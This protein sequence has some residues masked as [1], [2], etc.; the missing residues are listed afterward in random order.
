[1]L[2]SVRT[3]S[4]FRSRSIIIARTRISATAMEYIQK[5]S[6]IKIIPANMV[7]AIDGDLVK[8]TDEP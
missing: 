3:H 1:M 7:C 2:I 6:A 5:H 8:L 4:A